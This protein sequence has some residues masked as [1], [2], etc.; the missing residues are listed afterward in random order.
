MI[1][2]LDNTS[3]VRR[4]QLSQGPTFETIPLQLGLLFVTAHLVSRLRLIFPFP[5]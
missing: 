3:I 5:F 4:L 2:E 1:C